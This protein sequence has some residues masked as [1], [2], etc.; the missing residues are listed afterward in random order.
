LGIGQVDSLVTHARDNKR[1]QRSVS[2][3]L[4]QLLATVMWHLA[5]DERYVERVGVSLS[6]VEILHEHQRLLVVRRQQVP[7]LVEFCRVRRRTLS[8]FVSLGADVFVLDFR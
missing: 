3:L 7:N 8:A 6:L 5:A 4:E 1:R 2:E